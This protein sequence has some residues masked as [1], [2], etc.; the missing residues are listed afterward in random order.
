[1]LFIDVIYIVYICFTYSNYIKKAYINYYFIGF[2][3]IY[4]KNSKYK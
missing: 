3:K 4:S 2:L 1:M